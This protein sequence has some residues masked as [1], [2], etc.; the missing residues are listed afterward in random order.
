MTLHQRYY[1]L[2]DNDLSRYVGFIADSGGSLA[3]SRILINMSA[4]RS[5]CSATVIKLCGLW[6]LH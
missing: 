4:C 5:A 1:I 6:Y 3:V 2:I